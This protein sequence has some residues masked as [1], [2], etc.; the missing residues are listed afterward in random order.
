MQFLVDGGST[1]SRVPLTERSAKNAVFLRGLYVTLGSRR[2]LGRNCI[3]QAKTRQFQEFANPAAQT[4]IAK[5]SGL[6]QNIVLISIHIITLM[7]KIFF[8]LL[9]S[10]FS[11]LFIYQRVALIQKVRFQG[12]EMT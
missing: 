8:G 11:S 4:S 5:M 7:Y 3:I 1:P 6:T 12:P 9:F 2:Q 10:D